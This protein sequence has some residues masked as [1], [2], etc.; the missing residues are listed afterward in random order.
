VADWFIKQDDEQEDLGPLRPPEL[1][2]MVREGQVTR[3]SMIRKGDSA[4]F[5]A[6]NV[7]GLFEAAMRPTIEHFCPGCEHAVPEP[8]TVC[9]FCGR[10]LYQAITKITENTIALPT[11]SLQSKAGHSV[12]NWLKKKKI[13]KDDQ[14]D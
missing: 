9:A 14:K 10:E 7:G 5:E 2:K 6:G 3:Q 11:D 8:P 4:F 1:L 12:R 13:G